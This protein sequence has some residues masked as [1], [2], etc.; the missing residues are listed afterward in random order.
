MK[1]NY[2]LLTVTDGTTETPFLL[3]GNSDCSDIPTSF[4][5]AIDEAHTDRVRETISDI[6]E[7]YLRAHGL[8][9]VPLLE[10]IR[11]WNKPIYEGPAEELHIKLAKCKHCNRFDEDSGNCS[12]CGPVS[13]DMSACEDF[14]TLPGRGWRLMAVNEAIPDKPLCIAR[15]RNA[16]G[17]AERFKDADAPL[18]ADALAE[19]DAD[20]AGELRE[21]PD[22]YKLTIEK[23]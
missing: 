12:G 6:P 14:A 20:V 5:A 11:K 16:T 1:E 13:P 2:A 8:T 4:K 22:G 21:L 19:L 3:I 18:I 15:F 17:H 7:K 10:S 9:M 23:M